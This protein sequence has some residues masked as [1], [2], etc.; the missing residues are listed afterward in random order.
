ML[1]QALHDVIH[2][3]ETLL[4]W[5][6]GT[7]L[8]TFIATLLLVPLLLTNLPA[9]YFCH[10]KRHRAPWAHHHPLIRGVLL[11][12]K[13]ILGTLF[14]MAGLLMLF[15]PGQG[16]LTMVMGIVLL[17]LPGKYRLESWLISRR[18]I[19]RGINWL[20]LRAGK[21]LLIIGREEEHS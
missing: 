5:L 9:D 1:P 19:L 6:A 11:I 21:P 20:R 8:L 17:D 3:N 7:S 12:G 16:L 10:G 2:A 13:N 15:L 14:F 18:P 4:W